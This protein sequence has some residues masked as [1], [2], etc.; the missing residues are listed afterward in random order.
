MLAADLGKQTEREQR[1]A[2]RGHREEN[3]EKLRE[4]ALKRLSVGHISRAAGLL[5]SNGIADMSS[6]AVRDAL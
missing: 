2:W 6:E 4:K 1:M 5:S 3:N